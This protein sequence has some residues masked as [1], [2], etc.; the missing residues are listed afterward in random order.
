MKRYT[1]A[2]A[3][4]LADHAGYARAVLGPLGGE[5]AETTRRYQGGEGEVVLPGKAGSP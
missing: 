2:A 3:R 5:S 4:Q 1:D